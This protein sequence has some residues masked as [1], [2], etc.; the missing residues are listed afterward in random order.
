M[1]QVTTNSI[2][3][4]QQRQKQQQQ[5]MHQ[6]ISQAQTE[7]GQLLLLTGNGKGKTTGGFGTLF[8]ALGHE[9]KV[10]CV[11]FIK[12][13]QDCG[14]RK[15]VERLGV[16]LVTMSTGFSWDSEDKAADKR[17]AQHT[18]EQAKLFLADP[19]LDLVL[20]DELTYMLSWDFLLVDEVIQALNER[21]ESMSV[22]ITGRAAHRELKAICDTV[23]EVRPEKHA[24]KA[25]LKARRGLDW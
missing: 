7:R 21:P 16:P 13:Q 25:G 12:G 8:R 6:A 15:L 9:Q 5:K 4:Q 20:L 2:Q 1:S 14:E 19:S 18:W 22:V 3:R 10:A 11:Q 23:S 24:F 17:A